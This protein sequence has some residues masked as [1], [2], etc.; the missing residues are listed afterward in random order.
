M[1]NQFS[2]FHIV[3]LL[4]YAIH[5]LESSSYCARQKKKI[6]EIKINQKNK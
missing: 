5:Q 1:T 3:L 2:V 6:E 4:L